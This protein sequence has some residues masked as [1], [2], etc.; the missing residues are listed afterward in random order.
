[1]LTIRTWDGHNINDGTNYIAG[2]SPGAEWGLP[3]A[4]VRTVGRV[5]AWP[6]TTGLDRG[7]DELSVFI[8]IENGANVR[9]LRGQLLRWFDPEDESPKRLVIADD[10]DGTNERYKLAICRELRPIN[11]GPVAA[12]DLFRATLVVDGDVRW[13]SVT[14]D[15]DTWAIT[16]TGQTRAIVNGGEDE[17]YP[18]LTIEPTAGKTGGF[19]YRHWVSVVW[20]SPNAGN[21]YPVMI[22]FDTATPIAATEMEAAG[23]DLR[24]LV[25]GVTTPITF[26]NIDDPNTKIWF[27]ANF[28]R[29]PQLEL[30]TA[31]LAGDTVTSLDLDDEVEMALLPDAGT[32]LIGSEA[33]VYTGRSLIDRQLTGVT[34]AAKGTAAANHSVS[35]DVWWIQRD[36]YLLY[37]NASPPAP[38]VDNYPPVFDTAAS[39]NETWVYDGEFG[40]Q[41]GPW[42]GAW[43]NSNLIALGLVGGCYTESEYE[44]TTPW[45]VLGLYLL[46]GSAVSAWFAQWWHLENP[47]GIVNAVW[48]KGKI[49]A[50]VVDTSARWIQLRYW[51]RGAGSWTNQQYGTWYLSD[52]PL[53]LANTW[54]SQADGHW[55]GMAPANFGAANVADWSPADALAVV[56]YGSTAAG[57]EHYFEFG[58]V[59]VS[60]ND[61]ETP[62]V[63]VGA[64]QGNYALA[65]TITNQATGDA[66]TVS[67]VMDVN[68]ELEID[69]DLRT[70]T[71]L[72]DGSGQ[73]QAVAFNTARRHWLRLLPGSNTLR[74]DDVGTN[75]V[76]VTVA[77]EERYY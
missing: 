6:V 29:A 41:G 49:R 18:V 51:V 73:F 54:R 47:C 43:E 65:A 26:E 68:G 66:I 5:G 8:S 67:Y 42:P 34:R 38:P 52:Y 19:D 71:D 48:T 9:T 11:I 53:D 16:A 69:T 55:A 23:A 14:P 2:F 57:G 39:D 75:G 76:K 59:T 63:S 64:Q 7:D 37:G 27:A 13:R 24:L 77:W 44:V 56:R 46:G 17:A 20:R 12:C 61:A 25:D 28:S 36:V 10:S 1:M 70:V 3:A 32:V 45:E 22:D 72:A 15:S 58:A 50:E 33:F 4:G 62:L 74:W 35:D 31:F 21:N 40:D 30:R 60:L